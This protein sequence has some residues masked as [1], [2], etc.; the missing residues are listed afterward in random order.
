MT[1]RDKLAEADFFLHKLRDASVLDQN[2]LWDVGASNEYRYY[3][4]A[5]VWA[6][7][8]VREHLLYDYARMYWPNLGTGHHLDRGTLRLIAE[9][10]NH[11]EAKRFLAWYGKAQGRI[12][13]D[14]DAR[15]VLAVRK[16][17]AHRGRT[18]ISYFPYRSETPT[19]YDLVNVSGTMAVS[20]YVQAATVQRITAYFDGHPD[21]QVE[22]TIGDTLILMN[23]L[24][25]EAENTF[26]IPPKSA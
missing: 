2:R 24:V 21:K 20:T 26:G 15:T 4:S 18:D 6:V 3:V 10:T 8:G 12:E 19:L 25:T 13:A 1:A 16:V 5:C 11:D 14:A 7:I 9:A 17:E 23:T 22:D